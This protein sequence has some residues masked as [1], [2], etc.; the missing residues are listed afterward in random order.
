LAL[1]KV[2]E[3]SGSNKPLL[4]S[5]PTQPGARLILGVPLF[6][7]PEV[8]DDTVWSIP[9][10]HSLVVTRSDAAVT[11][12]RSAFFGS[13]RCAIRAVLRVGFGFTYEAAIAKITLSTAG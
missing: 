13:D 3:Q 10:Q 6:V 2:K 1:A 7:S 8:A 9:K 12:D 4:G 11:S 5:D